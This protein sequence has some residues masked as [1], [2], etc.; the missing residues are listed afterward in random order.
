RTFQ[1]V[2]PFGNLTLLENVMV[3]AFNRHAKYAEAR[4]VALKQLDFVGLKSRAHIRMR[5]LTFPEQKKVE[6]ARALATEPQLLFL[7]EIMSG[8]K[9]TAVLELL[10]LIR[11]IGDHD[12]SIVFLEH[13]MA[14]VM[15]LSDRL[16]VMH[17][18]EFLSVGKPEEVNEDPTLLE[19]YLGGAI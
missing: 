6:L 2:Q 11:D 15:S 3:G 5:D 4:E 17:H 8:F 12:D 1:I 13:F 18:G 7:D 10:Q 16:N 19:A 9:H 14:A